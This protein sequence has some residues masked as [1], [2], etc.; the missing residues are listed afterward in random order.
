MTS[1]CIWA[2]NS[3]EG[4]EQASEKRRETGIEGASEF[5]PKGRSLDPSRGMSPERDYL[6]SVMV[7]KEE[8]ILTHKMR[9][10]SQGVVLGKQQK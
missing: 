7:V 3:P 4:W 10:R 6:W 1:L 8:K 5:L 9:G 2:R